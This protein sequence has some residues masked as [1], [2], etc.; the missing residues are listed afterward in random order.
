MAFYVAIVVEAALLAL[1][2]NEEHRAATPIH[3][4]DLAAVI[5]G[6][7]VGL[8]LAHLLAF[9]LAAGGMARG[10]AGRTDVTLMAAQVAGA[11]FVALVCT[12]PVLLG[13]HEGALHRAIWAPELIIATAG[14][15]SARTSGRGHA[16]SALIGVGAAL[17]ALAV[18]LLKNRLLGH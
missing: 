7:T 15:T 17:A 16:R 9:Q 3:G 6:T 8:A 18:A 14:Y 13:D 11:A 5:W 2:A 4:A 1:W 10:R 12:V